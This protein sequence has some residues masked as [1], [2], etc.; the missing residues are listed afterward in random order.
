MTPSAKF[1]VDRFTGA[2]ALQ[3]PFHV[4]L[5]FFFSGFFDTPTAQ[6]TEPILMVDG[7][8]GVFP[9]KEVPLGGRVAVAQKMWAWHPK[10][11]LFW[12]P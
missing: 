5:A 4:D 8:N 10:N 9:P 11:P 1:G 12:P 3:P 6:T 7:S 2:G